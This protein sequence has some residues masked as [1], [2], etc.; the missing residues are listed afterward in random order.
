[1]VRPCTTKRQRILHTIRDSSTGTKDSTP[2]KN[3]SGKDVGK[4]LCNKYIPTR[5]R[6]SF[7]DDD[8]LD[9]MAFAPTGCPRHLYA[10][11]G[12]KKIQRV[13]RQYSKPRY[14][15]SSPTPNL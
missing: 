9:T 15:H 2:Q 11:A 8:S 5:S 3:L 7:L 10:R 6:E 14:L 13:P 4:G 12:E 1:M